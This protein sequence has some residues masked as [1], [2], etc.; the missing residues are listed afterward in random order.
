MITGLC[1]QQPS[2][3]AQQ[4]EAEANEISKE[5]TADGYGRSIELLQSA[6]SQYLEE[7]RYP[8]YSRCSRETG[9]LLLI[10]SKFSE[11]LSTIDQALLV[12]KRRHLQDEIIKNSGL[13]SLIMLRSG[14]RK[15][16]ESSYS[17]ALSLA[18]SSSDPDAVAVAN[19]AAGEYNYFFGS[20]EDTYNFFEVCI[21][22]AE[23]SGDQELVAEAKLYLGYTLIRQGDPVAALV[24]IQ[25]AASMFEELADRRGQA[26]AGNGLG[27]VFAV[28][29]DDG[30]A[31]Q[32]Y[33]RAYRS[34]PPNVDMIEKGNAGNGLATIYED[35]NESERATDF[36]NE[37]VDLFRSAK[38]SYGEVATLPSL[39]K[40]AL[41]TGDIQKSLDLYHQGMELAKKL[42]DEFNLAIMREGLGDVDLEN[43]KPDDAIHD[44]MIALSTYKR[45]GIKLPRIIRSLGNAYENKADLFTA[46][47]YYETA[48][49]SDR[50]VR[51]RFAESDVLYDLA[52]L[53]LRSGEEQKALEDAADSVSISEN[54]SANVISTK[55]KTSYF[56]TMY[57]K[58]QLYIELLMHEL[59]RTGEKKYGV[60]ALEASERARARSLRETLGLSPQELLKGADPALVSRQREL[61]VMLNA[62]ADLLTD[63]LNTEVSSPKIEILESEIQKLEND[64]DEIRSD[65]KKS[66]LRYANLGQESVLDLQKFQGDILDDST[67][68]VEFYLGSDE[69][70]VWLIDKTDVKSFTLP[71]R[72]QITNQVEVL[73]ELL[74]AREI[75]G[76]ES[77]ERYNARVRDSDNRF[78][79]EAERLSSELFGSFA[80]ELR[81]KRLLVIPD[82]SLNNFPF[83]ALPF[84]GGNGETPIGLVNEVVNE[85]SISTLMLVAETPDKPGVAT[86]NLLVFS[87]PV[88]SR[89]DP[90]MDPGSNHQPADA[91]S[92]DGFRF[93]RS[94]D[95]LPRLV[96][97]KLEGENVAS[98][99][100]DSTVLSGFAATR[101][102]A[103]DTTA[104]DYRILHFA[105]HG[106]VD[107]K[108]PELSGIV[109]SR[110]DQTGQR[111][112]EMLR[113]H[114][115]ATMDLPTELVV[116]SACDTG[117]GTDVKGEGL[118][119]L[120]NSFVE[121]GA[122]SV[123]SSMWKIDDEATLEFMNRFYLDLKE[124]GTTPAHA[125]RKAQFDMSQDPAY[126]SPYYWAAFRIDGDF[127]RAP[128]LTFSPIR[129]L[130]IVLITLIA[131]LGLSF[132]LFIALRRSHRT[133]SQH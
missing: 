88:F 71:P 123:I 80:S 103:L 49:T 13:R 100:G 53:E 24:Q 102:R 15:D 16:S 9:R 117:L 7:G 107:E 118:V 105:T 37:A 112:D 61:A 59:Q 42:G 124:P 23:R 62:K 43:G 60:L 85:A 132:A 33:E 19:Y 73:R 129:S 67:I 35:L 133:R 74:R 12:D 66:V 115:I 125:L 38:Y 128:S 111:L 127:R 17:L 106:L 63:L 46:R 45:I 93:A 94:L 25:V 44:Y 82:G 97:T 120:T 30:N 89:D 29:G 87:D 3:S 47:K 55:L 70:Y 130:P 52:R 4:K 79:K 122:H 98:I 1:G 81:G 31:L 5:W 72:D 91:A 32:N 84:P 77:P 96:G 14:N 110:F 50:T 51:D 76:D 41:L 69:S 75:K 57:E 39:A 18:R 54:L 95:N 58:Y 92:A 64:L 90:R 10:L 99:I 101:A 109:L 131:C 104:A 113:L 22:N 26:L 78:W 65:L 20:A 86:R 83:A 114:D 56:S 27:F 68:A 48:L 116:L 121:A 11:A 28:T 119:G 40:L 126:A 34:F 108:R 36:R 8:E 21:S 6:A 2:P